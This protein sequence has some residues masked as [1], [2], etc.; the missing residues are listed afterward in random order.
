MKVVSDTTAVTTLLQVGR[1][2]LRAGLFGRVL[3]PR[4]V[5]HELE[6]YHGMV[7]SCCELHEVA[8]SPRRRLLECGGRA[9][10]RHRFGGARSA[11]AAGGSTARKSGGA[12]AL[13]RRTQG[14][15]RSADAHVRANQSA[16]NELADEGVR[17]PRP[18]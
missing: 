14:A 13:C 16:P 4:S 2:D 17:A 5:H 3:I 6:R 12:T 1:V 15:S 10:R 9:E 7:P 8:D 11:G 18:R